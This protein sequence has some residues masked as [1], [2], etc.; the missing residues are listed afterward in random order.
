MTYTYPTVTPNG[1]FY[2]LN[3]W[4]APGKKYMTGWL[5]VQMANLVTTGDWQAKL[6]HVLSG[7][8]HSDHPV[9]ALQ[10]WWHQDGTPGANTSYWEFFDGTNSWPGGWSDPAPAVAGQWL[11]F[12]AQV[13]DSTDA[14][15]PNGRIIGRVYHQDGSISESNRTGITIAATGKFLNTPHF[16]YCLV[17]EGANHEVDTYWDDIY[18][19][20]TWQR[21]EICSGSAWASRGY[22]EIQ[23]PQT[24]WIDGQLQAKVNQGG[25]ANGT[26]AYLYVIDANG[27]PSAGYPVTFTSPSDATAPTISAFSMPATAASLTVNVSAFTASDNVGV[28]GYRITESATAPLASASGW[29]ASAPTS[30]TF[31]TAGSKTAFAWAKDAAGNVSTFKSA[32]VVITLPTSGPVIT[33]APSA[34]SHKQAITITGSGFGVKS[35]VAPMT[36]DPIDDQ[37]A[38][39]GLANGATIPMGVGMPWVKTSNYPPFY[40]TTNPE[41]SSKPNTRT[42]GEP[43]AGPEI[44][45]AKPCCK[46][47]IIPFNARARNSISHGG[48]TAA[49]SRTSVPPAT[50]PTNSLGSH[51]T[52]SGRY[53]VSPG[54]R[55]C[56]RA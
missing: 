29:S 53:R 26:R 52:V 9:L 39:A 48:F 6:I 37:P 13:Q 49:G 55:R 23:I 42:N 15:T 33:A 17:N 41:A 22:C 19:D 30:F 12:E 50:P 14:S 24:Q 54:N 27:N 25:F 7:S 51:R 36:W 3:A 16:G 11:R 56:T 18:L 38:Y 43:A 44:G 31:S 47:R 8:E 1:N 10:S 4:T 46:R 2:R 20:D 5:Y 45:P 35:P 32:W 40:K 34:V 28:T 21:V